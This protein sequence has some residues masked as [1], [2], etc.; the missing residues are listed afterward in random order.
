MQQEMNCGKPCILCFAYQDYKTVMYSKLVVRQLPVS[1][2]ISVEEEECHY[3]A[4]TTEDYN[5]LRRRVCYSD[6]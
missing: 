4:M 2:D 3:L 5:G 6:L 1:K